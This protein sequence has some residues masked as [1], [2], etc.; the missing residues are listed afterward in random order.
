M[1]RRTFQ[2][3]EHEQTIRCSRIHY[4][5]KGVAHLVGIC[6][7]FLSLLSTF[8]IT[9]GISFYLWFEVSSIICADYRH[10][11]RRAEAETCLFYVRRDSQLH[12]TKGPLGVSNKSSGNSAWKYTV[13]FKGH[14]GRIPRL[15]SGCHPHCPMSQISGQILKKKKKV[16]IERTR[17]LGATGCLCS[18]KAWRWNSP[19]PHAVLSDRTTYNVSL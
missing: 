18:G 15:A 5:C 3:E 16:K 4:M 7:Q 13:W 8:Y 2:I 10:R 14:G 19:K 6:L 1:W 11:G 17:Q 9:L 12:V